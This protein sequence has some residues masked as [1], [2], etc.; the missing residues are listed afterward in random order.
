MSTVRRPGRPRLAGRPAPAGPTPATVPADR[1]HVALLVETSLAPGRD[2]L[3][4]IARYVREHGP[5]ST[6]L[7]PRSLEESMPAWL[8]RWRGHG[9][10]VR[11][12]NQQ[13]ADAVRA[14]R[15]PVVDVL[16]V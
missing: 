4:G 1:P 2:I 9:I 5:W 3:R 16:G 6:F 15:L 13:I 12:Q 8:G 11:V 14:T 7:E 10:I